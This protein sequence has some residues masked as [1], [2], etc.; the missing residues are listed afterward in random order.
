[1]SQ[2]QLILI[3]R[4]DF[5]KNSNTSWLYMSLWTTVITKSKAY[6]KIIKAWFHIFKTKKE[7]EDEKKV[8]N[9][10]VK[11]DFCCF[12]IAH[13]TFSTVCLWNYL[14]KTTT[15]N[16]KAQ[17]YV[18]S[19]FFC[20]SF[21]FLNKHMNKKNNNKINTVFPRSFSHFFSQQN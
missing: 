1:M 11:W 20:V 7:E 6:F 14:L 17:M 19:W 18:L 13:Y 3:S 16:K 5:I 4:L 2:L 12:I 15:T 10:K 21:F 8:N 9:F